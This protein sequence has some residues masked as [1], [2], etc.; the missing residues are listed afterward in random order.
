MK[1]LFLF[2]L[3]SCSLLSMVSCSFVFSN[4]R[5]PDF[6][7]EEA[8][9]YQV[10]VD[11][12][13]A[14]REGDSAKV[15]RCYHPDVVKWTSFTT[16]KGEKVLK[17]GSLQKF[18]DAVGTPHDEVWDEKIRNTKINIDGNLA[19]VWTEYAFYLGDKFSHCGVDALLM[20][21][22]EEGWK[23]LS[24]AD[25]RRRADCDWE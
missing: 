5:K 17:Q 13:D 15:H 9:V 25:T 11:L 7:N 16:K 8:L 19:Q 22:T 6:T 14:M 3:I 10:V 23:I 20:T 4:E 24:L 2:S 21:K 1:K 12:F 18:L